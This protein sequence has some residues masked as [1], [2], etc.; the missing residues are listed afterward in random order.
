[1]QEILL[2]SGIP[3]T[4]IYLDENSQNTFENITNGFISSI[5]MIQMFKVSPLF[6]VNTI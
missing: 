4:V 1:M 3:K 6:R 2:T 5:L